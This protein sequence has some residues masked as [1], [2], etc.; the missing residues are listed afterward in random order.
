M[1]IIGVENE[2]LEELLG[3]KTDSYYD[4]DD[5]IQMELIVRKCEVC[6]QQKLK[7]KPTE[8]MLCLVSHNRTITL[9]QAIFRS[10]RT[11]SLKL[12][13]SLF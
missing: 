2:E 12:T 3:E 10:Q 4:D 7:L 8:K 9:H 5:K 11:K 1:K 6:R 13:K